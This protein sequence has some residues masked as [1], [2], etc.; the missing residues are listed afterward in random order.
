[1][2]LL[3]QELLVRRRHILE[4]IGYHML[5]LR[6]HLRAQRVVNHGAERVV[7]ADALLQG[8]DL[9]PVAHGLLL[10]SANQGVDGLERK[11]GSIVALGIHTHMYVGDGQVLLHLVL[12]VHIYYLT[13]DAHRT[14]HVV[15]LLRRT[16]HS[17][18]YY[19]IS[20]HLAGYV[21]GIVILQSAIHQHHVAQSYRREGSR[22]RHRG[23]HGLG[24]TS[25]V[26]VHLTIV[27]DIRCHTGKGYA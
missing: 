13:D 19:N 14:T 5:F 6:H 17:N 2:E 15:G 7:D 16:L 22:Y 26:E 20:P 4:V 18:T 9:V 8:D 1:M 24:Q 3:A 11:A 23:T 21:N 27:D 10:T 12:T 25:A